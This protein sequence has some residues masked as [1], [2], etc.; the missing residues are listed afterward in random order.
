MKFNEH[1][2]NLIECADH[3][4]WSR[5]VTGIVTAPVIKSFNASMKY[6]VRNNRARWLFPFLDSIGVDHKI[7]PGNNEI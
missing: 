5:R 1:I 7:V 3:I 2:K 4:M 6:M